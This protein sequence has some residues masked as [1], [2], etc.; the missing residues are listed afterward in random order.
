[1]GLGD[2]LR[3]TFGGKQSPPSQEMVPFLDVEAGR[4]VRIPVSE[5]R[6]GVI[7][8]RV[9][10]SDEVVWALPEQLREGDV[11]HPEF[12][13]GVRDYIRQI[14]AA[15]A[16][17]RP[18]SFE[19]W[20]DG[21]RRDTNPTREIAIWSHAADVFT[22][23]ASEEPSADRRR[24]LYRCVVTCLTTGPD[25]VWKVLR[26]EVLSRAEAE[27]VVNRFFGKTA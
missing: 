2:W 5:L 27:V 6:P 17:Q 14:Q 21:F 1:M 4:V 22:A 18:L 26:P 20:E 25:A 15:F 7:Q 23:F 3:K 10:G 8:V 11:K 9:H 12:D 24:D 16:E 13:E 19:E